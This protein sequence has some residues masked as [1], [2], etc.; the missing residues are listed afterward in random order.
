[1]VCSPV[2]FMYIQQQPELSCSVEWSHAARVYR[3]C[4]TRWMLSLVI[5]MTHCLFHADLEIFFNR[6]N[7]QNIIASICMLYRCLILWGNCCVLLARARTSNR[8][9]YTNLFKNQP[10]LK[11]SKKFSSFVFKKKYYN[12]FN[13]KLF[14]CHN[15]V[16]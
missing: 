4:N 5:C 9:R 2:R 11:V 3:G 6:L 12:L 10:G 7:I 1:M 8:A 13:L 16:Y 15:K 14:N